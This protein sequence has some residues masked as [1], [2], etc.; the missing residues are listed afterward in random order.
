MA[1]K[2]NRTDRPKIKIETLK[3]TVDQCDFVFLFF[4][5]FFLPGYVF[6]EITLKNNIKNISKKYY[7][8]ELFFRN[9]FEIIFQCYFL[10]F[11]T[12]CALIKNKNKSL[13]TKNIIFFFFLSFSFS[14]YLFSSFLMLTFLNIFG[15]FI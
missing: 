3:E 9:V 5:Q 1:S 6:R 4:T 11:S 8:L 14:L 10:H 12:F 2:K 15:F 7:L 13:G